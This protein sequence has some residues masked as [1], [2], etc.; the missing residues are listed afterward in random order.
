L[1]H[2]CRCAGRSDLWR[3][4]RSPFVRQS[5]AL[6]CWCWL[7]RHR[8]SLHCNKISCKINRRS[9]P[10]GRWRVRLRLG[11][12][13][14][15]QSHTMLFVSW[16]WQSNG[17]W[18]VN[19]NNISMAISLRNRVL[20]LAP[21]AAQSCVQTFPIAPSPKREYPI[22]IEKPYKSSNL[23]LNGD[24]CLSGLPAFVNMGTE[25][26]TTAECVVSRAYMAS[27]VVS[28]RQ[29][30]RF[31]CCGP[32]LQTLPYQRARRCFFRH[33]PEGTPTQEAVY[34][35]RVGCAF[36][37]HAIV[38]YTLVPCHCCNPPE[39]GAQAGCSSQRMMLPPWLLGK[40]ALRPVK[41]LAGVLVIIA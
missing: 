10:E 29:R 23:H 32:L 35:P 11:F 6:L 7:A 13:L 28:P 17:W 12:L 40:A 26:C 3:L 37:K 18:P 1:L 19:S 36:S 21:K 24:S 34:H 38:R 8:L 25:F 30:L 15:P 27:K 14:L 33:A 41:W 20:Q 31:T 9:L 4:L 22:V 2:N 16:R 39:T 5:K